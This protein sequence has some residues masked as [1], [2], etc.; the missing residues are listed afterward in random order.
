MLVTP[1]ADFGVLEDGVVFGVGDALGVVG[2]TL[3]VVGRLGDGSGLISIGVL[4][5]GTSGTPEGT[6]GNSVQPANNTTV[7]TAVIQRFLSF[8]R[9]PI[10]V[11]P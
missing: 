5:S 9:V 6:L 8:I 1:R 2:E 4:G 7:S 11:S 3:G 10:R